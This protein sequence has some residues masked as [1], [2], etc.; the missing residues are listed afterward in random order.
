MTTLAIIIFLVG[1]ALGRR[2]EVTILFP[3]I[4]IGLVSAVATAILLGGGVWLT[5]L[6]ISI[7]SVALEIGY[8]VGAATRLIAAANHTPRSHAAEPTAISHPVL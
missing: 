6:A 3:A 5:V 7:A 1:A 2:F 8:L 4:P